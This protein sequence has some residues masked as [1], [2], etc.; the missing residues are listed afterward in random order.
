MAQYR[1]KYPSINDY[2]AQKTFACWS[3]DVRSDIA[4]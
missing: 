3:G 2:L 1:N 4:A